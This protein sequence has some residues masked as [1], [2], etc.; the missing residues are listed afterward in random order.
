MRRRGRRIVRCGGRPCLINRAL[1]IGLGRRIPYAGPLVHG[2]RQS[3]SNALRRCHALPLRL[4]R[5]GVLVLHAPRGI[6]ARQVRAINGR[7]RACSR[8]RA[9]QNRARPRRRAPGSD[10][11]LRANVDS[12]NG[13]DGAPI[14]VERLLM[15]RPGHGSVVEGPWAFSYRSTIDGHQAPS[16]WTRTARRM[17]RTYGH[18]PPRRMCANHNHGRPCPAATT[19][20][21]APT[22]GVVAPRATMVRQPPPG[23]ARDPG[24]AE[25]RVIAP[26][27]GPIG[28]PTR[29]DAGRNP[30]IALALYGIPIA[31][32]IQII[33]VFA[34][35]IG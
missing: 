7:P 21:P 31:I 23:I 35:R 33:P 5:P 1:V 29:S 3:L 11:S 30:D 6:V 13:R 19:R 15:I 2:L 26:I 16:Y 14:K 9:A 12:T 32:G 10:K 18:R 27:S 22:K 28:I 17:D 4:R 25:G 34:L 20:S 8:K 24:V